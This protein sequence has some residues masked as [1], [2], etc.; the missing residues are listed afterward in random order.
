M[1]EFKAWPKI[2]RLENETFYITEKLDGTNACIVIDEDDNIGAQSRT[3]IITPENDN[4][5]FAKWVKDNSEE[6]LTLGK[7][8]HYGEWWG[9]GIQRRYNLNEKRF[10]SFEYWREDLPKIVHKVPIVADTVEE[11][12]KRLRE[13]GSI[14]APGYNRPE[15]LIL[16]SKHYKSMYKVIIDK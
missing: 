1:I 6:L 8:Y 4:Y 12:L 10:S 13:E 16:V 9:Q 14:A 5:G 7:G 2:P 11:S 3:V 15:G